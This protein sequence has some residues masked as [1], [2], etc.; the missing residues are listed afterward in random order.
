M[1]GKKMIVDTICAV[2]RDKV[3]QVIASD[4]EGYQDTVKIAG[5][6]FHI[7]I[8]EITEEQ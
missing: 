1:I 4:W 8:N 2:F 6:I 7:A 5:R 3:I